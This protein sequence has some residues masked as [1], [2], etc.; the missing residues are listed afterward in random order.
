MAPCR[1]CNTTAPV[2]ADAASA[3]L[4]PRGAPFGLPTLFQ[5]LAPFPLPAP[6]NVTETRGAYIVSMD[7]PGVTPGD[8]SV[9][10]WRRMVTV[11]GR[12][13][14]AA[15]GA[16]GAD[17]F[18]RQFR[19]PAN[20]DE[21]AISAE[22]ENGV[23]TVT[24]PKKLVG[25][26]AAVAERL[27]PVSARGAAAAAA[28]RKADAPAA[29]AAAAEAPAAEAAEADANA[30]AEAGGFEV[31][32]AEPEADAEAAA[33]A[34][35]AAAEEPA[36]AADPEFDLAKAF[37]AMARAVRTGDVKISQAGDS[38]TFSFKK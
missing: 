3:G 21:E 36:P 20:A 23:L 8:V 31:V 29:E 5:A 6:M 4:W 22:L 7:L 35:A 32:A 12:R 11:R 17:A 38:M 18:E 24:A 1:G 2:L 10:V 25:V 15:G 37:E 33:P 34:A 14:A 19:L 13:A 9:N 30:E 27:I 16:A 28:P 26:A